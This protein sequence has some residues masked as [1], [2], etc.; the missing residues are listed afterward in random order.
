MR[1]KQPQLD[2]SVGDPEVA[3]NGDMGPVVESSISANPGLT[4]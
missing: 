4:P 2:Y 3:R 1:T